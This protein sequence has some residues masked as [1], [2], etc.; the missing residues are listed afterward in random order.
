MRAWRRSKRRRKR[1]ACPGAARTPPRQ[2]VSGGWRRAATEQRPRHR[3]RKSRAQ[4]AK[5][6][7]NTR[8]RSPP[9]APSIDRKS[10]VYGKSVDLG[11]RRITKKKKQKRWYGRMAWLN[12]TKDRRGF[13][14]VAGLS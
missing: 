12:S 2:R 1:S 4:S 9:A 3:R 11:G 10:V 8:T 5:G 7:R 14:R 13:G 6:A